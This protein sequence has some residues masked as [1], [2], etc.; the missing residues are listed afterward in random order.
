MPLAK[1]HLRRLRLR[2]SANLGV[3]ASGSKRRVLGRQ[4]QRRRSVVVGAV[5]HRR[6]PS[7]V[8][9]ARTRPNEEVRRRETVQFPNKRSGPADP[10][11]YT[12][13]NLARGINVLSCA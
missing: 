4:A 7:R 3:G 2:A 12:T 9:G 8:G 6:S 10:S 5:A 1:L 11:K 13:W